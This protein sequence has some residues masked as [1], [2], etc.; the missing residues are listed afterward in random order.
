MHVLDAEVGSAVSRTIRRVGFPFA[1]AVLAG[2]TTISYERMEQSRNDLAWRAHTHQVLEHIERAQTALL[3]ADASRRDYRLSR[4]RGDLDEMDA[5]IDV[6]ERELALVADLTRDNAS[7]QV[8]MRALR[9]VIAERLQALHDGIDLPGWDDLDANTRDEQRARQKHG[10]DLARLAS[11][12]ID[13]M[14]SEE[15]RLLDEREQRAVLSAAATQSTLLYGSAI[16]VALVALFYGSLVVENRNRLRVQ[17]DLAQANA[18]FKAVLEGTTDVIAVKDREGR[19]LLINPAGC[20]NLK[21]ARDEILGKTD[22]DFLTEDTAASVMQADAAI[23]RSGET[24]TFEQVASVDDQTWTFLSTKAPYKSA[25]G[26]VLGVIAISRDITERKRMEEGM[27]EQNVERGAAISLLQRQSHDLTALSEMARLLQSTY[28]VDEVYELVGQFARRLFGSAGG[29]GVIASS[30]TRVD[31]VAYW[32]TEKAEPPFQPTDCWALRTGR[33][34]ASS[35]GGTLCRHLSA[36]ERTTLCVPMVAQGETLGV[37]QLHG[38]LPRGA[39]EQLLDA[40]TE[41]LSLAIANLRLRETLRSQ[42]IRDPLTTL[43]NRR[44]M[45]ETLLREIARVKRA[46]APLSVIMV[47]IDHF[48]RLNDSAGHGAGDEV[49]KRVAQHLK[50]GVRREDVACRYGGEEFALILPELSLDCAVER[51]ERLRVDIE[52]LSFEIADQPVGPVT[53]SFGVA[54]FPVHGATGEALIRRAD[55]AL[56]Q[57]KAGGRNRVVAA[58]A[59]DVAAVR[60]ENAR[61]NPSSPP[62]EAVRVR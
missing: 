46:Q 44:Y 38:E 50:N 58:G 25:T 43:Y 26:E 2:V 61:S 51:A 47:D 5:R 22:L 12:M 54:C 28:A 49:L 57:A 24:R 39:R 52:G 40:F 59:L 19:Y 21:S 41:Q 4:E 29:F 30:R 7:Q 16:G 13:A 18:L 35:V 17:Q 11:V 10:S 56:Y 42:A 37:L 23:V 55:H 27:A 15:V 14:R 53:A 36:A 20:R 60:D 34:H 32:G 62:A 6:S 3:A 33:P 48:K 45:D 8:R 1:L 31:Q 9:P